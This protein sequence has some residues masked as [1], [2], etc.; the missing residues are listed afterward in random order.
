MAKIA[1]NFVQ[2]HAA[3]NSGTSLSST[4]YFVWLIPCEIVASSSQ[5]SDLDSFFSV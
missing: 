2:T 5:G 3:T 4:A 1:Q